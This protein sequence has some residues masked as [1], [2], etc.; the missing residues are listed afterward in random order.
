MAGIKHSKVITKTNNPD[1][2]VSTDNWNAEHV[3]DDASIP[4]SKLSDHNKTV[5]DSLGIDHTSLTNKG[6]NTHTEIDSHISSTSNPHNVTKTQV[7]LGNVTNEAQIAKSVGTTKGDIVVFTGDSTPTRLGVGA[8]DQVLTA[9]SSQATGIKWATPAGGAE[10]ENVVIAT[11][12]T[13]NAT[14]TLANATGLAFDVL[15]N[16]EYLIEGFIV[17]DTS[18]T[19]VGIKLSATAPASPTLMT[20]HFITDAANGTPDSSSFN[21]NDVTVTTSASPFTT[22]C[23]AAL[24]C[25]L[26]TGA[27]AGTFQ[28]RFAAETTGTVT[29][30]AGS[31]LRYRKVA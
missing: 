23:L 5:H 22:G 9:D 7:E 15:A 16:S 3:I 10:S 20:G 21:A 17:W 29:V 4:V 28:I 30:K 27:N 24:H 13:A 6:T 8:N 19:T 26:K 31:V 1:Y 12:D 18:A 14:T 2:D 11:Q 25:I